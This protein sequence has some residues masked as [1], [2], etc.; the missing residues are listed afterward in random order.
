MLELGI[1]RQWKDPFWNALSKM[2]LIKL[3]P[4]F[5]F[6]QKLVII[7]CPHQESLLLL[8]A[9]F[10]EPRAP[11]TA[12]PRDLLTLSPKAQIMAIILKSQ[13]SY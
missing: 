12:T 6:P 5:V 13:V 8:S 7:A 2:V 10:R 4:D 9:Q 11:Y 3:R 1:Y